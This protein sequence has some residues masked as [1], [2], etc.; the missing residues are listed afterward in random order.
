MK[1]TTSLRMSGLALVLS[2]SATI[3]SK[4]DFDGPYFLTPPAPGFYIGGQNGSQ[5]PA[6]IGNWTAWGILAWVNT[7]NAPLR[8]EL[9]VPT[10]SFFANELRFQTYAVADGTISFDYRTISRDSPQ[11]GAIHWLWQ[12]V[13]GS[14]SSTVLDQGPSDELRHFDFQ[15]HAGDQFGFRLVSGIDVLGP[16]APLWHELTIE[17]FIAPVPEP[18]A[19]SLLILGCAALV[20]HDRRR[21]ARTLPIRLCPRPCSAHR[22]SSGGS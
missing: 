15:V 14:P 10:G 22:R 16:G 1:R 4:A 11:G 5:L 12:P 6:S 7:S 18:T 3:S 17:N 2:F 20:S 19:W 9:G 13:E 8:L 21:R